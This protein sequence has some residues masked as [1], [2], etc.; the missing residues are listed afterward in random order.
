MKFKKIGTKM[1]T[2]IIP[3]VVLAMMILTA[4]SG[5]SS[6][7]IINNEI[8]RHMSSEL[9]AQLGNIEE[10]LEI[11][12]AT[13][14]ALSRTVATTYQTAD[15]KTYEEMLSQIINDNEIVLGSGIWFEP[16]AYDA[17]QKYMGPYVYKNGSDNVVTYDYS[18]E[19]YDYLNQPYY[20]L[21]KLPKKLLLQ[22]LI[23][24]LHQV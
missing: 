21:A 10:Y 6:R 16:Y 5:I 2:V 11:V 23:M 20:T 3:V 12:S 19:E 14:T 4:I 24:I 7:T 15:M 17:T 8:K 18:N 13:A 22:N 1:L 9:Q